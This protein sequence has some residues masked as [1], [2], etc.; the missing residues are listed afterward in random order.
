MKRTLLS[1]FPVSMALYATACG[2]GNSDVK[3]PPA[4]ML[5]PAPDAPKPPTAEKGAPSVDEAKKFIEQVE[6]DLKKLWVARDQA[7]WVQNTYITD[8]TDAVGARAEEA[9]SEYVTKAIKAAER[10]RGVKMPEDIARKFYFLNLAQVVPAPSDAK[11]R[12]ELAEVGVWLSGT[13]GKG[14]YCPTGKTKL[15]GKDGQT[16]FTLGDLSKVLDKSRDY[17]ELLEAWTGWHSISVGMRDKYSRYVELGNKGA[18]EIGFADMG[19]LWRSGYD[20]KPEE[21]EADNERMW[22]EVKP[23]YDELHC[24]VRT[25]LAKKYGKDKVPEKGPIPA[26]I[27]GNMWAQ[28]WQKLFDLLVPYPNEPSLNV[29]K[30]LEKKFPM[31]PPAGMKDDAKTFEFKNE[32]AKKFAKI[33]E[34]FFVSLGM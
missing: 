6:A 27:L 7:A 3:C 29:T 13:Y 22:S 32:N 2:G 26:H 25:R 11:D 34:N 18:K 20:M 17:D 1:L 4:V 19:A 14:K 12:A 9:T 16:C 15:K 5:A 23:L 24:Y 30:T 8:D 33:G 10:F 28:E 21:F 31:T